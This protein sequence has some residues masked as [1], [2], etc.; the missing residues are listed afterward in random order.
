MP[1][2]LPSARLNA[3]TL[4]KNIPVSVTIELT[5]RC[6]LSCRHCYLPETCG[7]ARPGRELSTAQ[8]EKILGQLARAGALYLVFTG[9]EP[10]L[11]SDLAELCRC[12]KKLAFDVRVFS[13]GLGLTPKLAAELAA[14]GV[15]GFEIS[16]Y[17]GP[18]VHDAI[19][20][21]P[22]SQVRSLNAARLLK[23]NGIKVKI[24]TPL[25]DVNFK[26]A[27]RLEKLAKREGFGISFDPVIAPGND[28][29]K[30]VLPLRLTGRRLAS[31]I[32]RFGGQP[33]GTAAIPVPG[34]IPLPP[35]PAGFICGAGRN[36]CAVDPAGNLYPCLQLPV[37]LGNLTRRPLG[38]I[39]KSAPWLKKW[40]KASV[41]DLKG[42]VSCP[43]SDY[44]S[45]CP[46]LSLLEEGDIFVPNKPACETAAIAR[47]AADNSAT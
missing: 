3:L 9:G 4:Q 46:G 34:E 35:F 17:G 8:W 6:P 21:Q 33:P 11:R 28:G 37:K 27:G 10:L 45:L 12:A 5:R 19:T 41:K 43:D 7:R 22:G 32:K 16:L 13:T 38:L 47:R 1:D 25:M 24:K 31:A 42:C 40:R 36:V 29:N 44:C 20:G 2:C 39:W 15:S 30:S 23:K 14:A 18:A 26:D